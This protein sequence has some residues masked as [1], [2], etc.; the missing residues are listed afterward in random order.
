[1]VKTNITYTFACSSK[2]CINSFTTDSIK[3][4]QNAGWEIDHTCS[5]TD[6]ANEIK[7][8]TEILCP[9]CVEKERI[10]KYASEN[11]YDRIQQIQ[12][13]RSSQSQKFFARNV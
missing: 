3:S 12:Q 5:S 4:A 1:M 9:E 13:M 2:D 11:I 6:P 10:K 7:S 8:I